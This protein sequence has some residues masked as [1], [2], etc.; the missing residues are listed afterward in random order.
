MSDS[1]ISEPGL[2][3]PTTEADAD[4][5]PTLG[6]YL[7]M[8]VLIGVMWRWRGSRMRLKLGMIE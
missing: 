6:A 4:D 2:A 1:L 7:P 8:T 3:G 5:Q